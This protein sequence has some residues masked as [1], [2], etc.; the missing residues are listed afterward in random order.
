MTE[1]PD[2]EFPSVHHRESFNRWEYQNISLAVVTQCAHLINELAQRGSANEEHI[3]ACVNPLMVVSSQSI[4]EVYPQ[5]SAFNSG[6]KILQST[7]AVERNRNTPEIIRY[8]LG[9]LVLRNKLMG[10][11]AMQTYLGEQLNLYRPIQI[12]Q[13]STEIGQQQARLLYSN[14]ANLYQET[15]STL[16]YRI[17]VQ[18]KMAFLQD[19]QVANRVRSLLLAGIRSAVLWHQLGGRRWQLLIYRKR[20][21][22]SVSEIRRKLMSVV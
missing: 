16:P 1:K 7:L 12:E 11:S 2:Q 15:I 8:T 10:N 21:R 17:Q 3:L 20:L 14:L 5:I 22:Y 6:L 19:D 9:M 18:G 13:G 4:T